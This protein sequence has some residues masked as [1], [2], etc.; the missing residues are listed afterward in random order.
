MFAGNGEKPK[1]TEFI[2]YRHH[3]ANSKL[4]GRCKPVVVPGRSVIRAQFQRAPNLTP[5]TD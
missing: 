5:G 1:G 2:V 3:Y 4:G